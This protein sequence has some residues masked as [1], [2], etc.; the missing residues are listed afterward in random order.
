MVGPKF[1]APD[2]K[3]ELSKEEFIKIYSSNY[4]LE[5]NLSE[6]TLEKEEVVK[7]IRRSSK[8]VEEEIERLLKDG[9][10]NEN[11]IIHILAWKVGKIK[12]AESDQAESFVYSSDW[13]NCE[14]FSAKL[15]GKELVESDFKKFIE[16][17][18]S[19]IIDLEDKVNK[20]DLQS[21]MNT[22]KEKSCA[23]IGTVY[24]ITLLYF[25]SRGTWPIYDKY[26]QVAVTAILKGRK[27]GDPIDYSELPNKNDSKFYTLMDET[28]AYKKYVE[29]LKG[30]F[31]SEY[32]KR[33]VDRA[34]WV[35]GHLFNTKGAC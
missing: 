26:A 24:M 34:L 27:P 21:V 31:G 25:I 32:N 7:G 35:Y 30:I 4:F 5:Q 17:I 28:G 12:H 18:Q 16:Y 9:I 33:D 10:K 15:Y 8:W 20:R 13:N 6:Q 2:K 29:N 14:N 19:H 3:S 11:D 1:Y 23:G 22:L